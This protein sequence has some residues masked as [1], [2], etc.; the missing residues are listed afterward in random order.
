MLKVGTHHDDHPLLHALTP[1][2]GQLS[3]I[4]VSIPNLKASSRV[5]HRGHNISIELRSLKG[6]L[7]VSN[8]L[9]SIV[10]MKRSTKLVTIIGANTFQFLPF[11]LFFLNGIKT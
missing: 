1:S 4:D 10:F 2:S 6:H 8:T 3:P 7:S 11:I 5:S 9:L